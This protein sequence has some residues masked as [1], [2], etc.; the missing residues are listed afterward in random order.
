MTIRA[1]FRFAVLLLLAVPAG[2]RVRAPVHV[3][4]PA[5]LAS[6]VGKRV[7]VSVV[8]SPAET[9]GA[10]RERLVG[11]DPLPSPRNG[12]ASAS[13]FRGSVTATRLV[14]ARNLESVSPIRLVS[15]SDREMNDV[16]L[17]SVA[18]K[19]GFDFMLQ[20]QVVDAPGGMPEGE[21]RMTVS[22]RLSELNGDRPPIGI[23]VVVELEAAIARH[24]DLAWLGERESALAEAVVRETCGLI[25][26]SIARREAQLAVSYLTPGSRGVRRGNAAAREGN[27]A[28][29]QAI[30]R[31]TIRD[32]PAQSAAR[33]NLAIAAVAEQDFAS[34]RR[35][36]RQAVARHPTGIAGE[37]LVWV[38]LMQRQYHDA[39]G[40]PDPPEGWFV[41]R[42]TDRGAGRGNFAR[43]LGRR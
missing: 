18:S 25:A 22:W 31:E 41:S 35:L 26:P 19:R 32:H 28:A 34:A 5:R 13:K 8:A 23:P 42:P 20:G 4:Q 37:N 17:A 1:R 38:E 40:L 29:A 3:W 16:A 14:D 12:S 6:T 39:F 9:A 10:I 21:H 33:V 43:D 15:A 27:W 24:P 2:C 11:R 30:W 36:A 7:A